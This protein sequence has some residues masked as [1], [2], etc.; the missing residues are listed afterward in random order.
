MLN[1][2]SNNIVN[3]SNKAE[4]FYRD[5]RKVFSLSNYSKS[6]PKE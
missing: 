2:P 3:I 6:N 1:I 5:Y 4:R